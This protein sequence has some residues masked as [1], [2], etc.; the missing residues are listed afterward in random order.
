MLFV[1]IPQIIIVNAFKHSSCWLPYR[2]CLA[3]LIII[4][5]E[6]VVLLCV[7]LD[8]PDSPL[9]HDSGGGSDVDEQPW[10]GSDTEDEIERLG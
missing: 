4:S 5:Q 1:F 9:Q 7:C 10:S 8:V 6:D 3:H 2:S